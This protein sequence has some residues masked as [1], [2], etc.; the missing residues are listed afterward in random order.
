M[1]DHRL[2]D[3]AGVVSAVYAKPLR[4]LVG[5]NR[6][7]DRSRRK[8]RLQQLHVMAVRALVG[9]PDRHPCGVRD[10]RTLRPP[11]GSIGGIWPV[12]SPPGGALVIASSAAK[13]DQSIPILASYSNSP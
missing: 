5:V 8:R 10:E 4:L 2:A 1:G 9:D 6:P 3:R 7:G 13:N 11:V 12:F